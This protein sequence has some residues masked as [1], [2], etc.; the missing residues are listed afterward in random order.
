MKAYPI[1][2]AL[3]G[4]FALAACTP[5]LP[6]GVKKET[7]DDAVS[8]AIGD[9][10]T[11][12]L[13]A[14]VSDGQRIYRYNSATQCDRALPTCD[15]PQTRKIKDL[16]AETVAEKAPHA[17]SCPSSADGLRSVGWASGV[18]PKSGLAYAAMMEGKRALPGMVMQ[19]RL[20]DAF[21]TAGLQ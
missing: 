2:A 14:R 3:M 19:D 16:L 5:S 8:R 17:A 4:A 10:A 11:C 20:A 6:D 7:L 15:S 1:M 9:P 21:K 13:L 18:L 12:V